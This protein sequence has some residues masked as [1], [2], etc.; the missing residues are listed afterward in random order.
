[1]LGCGT[2]RPEKQRKDKGRKTTRNRNARFRSF[3]NGA[4]TIFKKGKCLITTPNKGQ[5]KN[6][7]K[8]LNFL[9]F[10]TTM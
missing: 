8:A 2:L 10:L 9:A 4:R 1:M 6:W 5:I 7:L 3:E